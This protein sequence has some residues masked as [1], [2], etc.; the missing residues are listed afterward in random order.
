MKKFDADHPMR[1]FVS[2]SS[3]LTEL[4]PEMMTALDDMMAKMRSSSSAIAMVPMNWRS[5]I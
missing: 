4:T 1:V 2:G 5:G 3:A